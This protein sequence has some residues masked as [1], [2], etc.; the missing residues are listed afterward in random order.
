MSGW[1]IAVIGL[2]IGTLL[3]VVAFII[4]WAIAARGNDQKGER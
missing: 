3:S 4:G 1:Q 2:S